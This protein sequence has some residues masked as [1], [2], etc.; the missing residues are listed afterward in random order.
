MSSRDSDECLRSGPSDTSSQA[1]NPHT[2]IDHH[3]RRADSQESKSTGQKFT[4]W[5]NHQNRVHSTFDALTGECMTGAI[6]QLVEFPKGPLLP[7]LT[8]HFPHCDL[9]W[10]ILGL[11][12]QA[13]GHTCSG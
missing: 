8:G 12:S 7:T 4:A 3:D 5:R 1:G 13:K 6:D 11:L 10:T 2:R 9:V